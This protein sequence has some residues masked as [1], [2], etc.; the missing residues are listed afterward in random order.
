MI[1]K[2]IIEKAGLISFSKEEKSKIASSSNHLRDII[3]NKSDFRD[4]FLGG[5]YKRHTMVKGISDVD[6]YYEYIGGGTPQTAL[7]NLRD[8]LKNTFPNTVIKQDKPSILVDFQKIAFNITPVKK[9]PTSISIPNSTLTLWNQINL[10]KLE[11]SVKSL[12]GKNSNF[13]NLIKIL[14]LWNSNYNKGIKNYRL[15]EMVCNLFLS[16]TSSNAISDWLWTFFNQNGYK[17]DA[18]KMF[19]LMKSNLNEG[20]LKSAWLKYID[21]K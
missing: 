3:N 15:E 10:S 8:Y 1:D 14:K 4:S 5:S 13:L 20:Q 2:F 11:V 6:I 9:G 12:S 16:G 17:G 21:R 7:A 18:N 19:E